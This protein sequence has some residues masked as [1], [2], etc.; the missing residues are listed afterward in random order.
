LFFESAGRPQH[1]T[2]GGFVDYFW[3]E[4]YP[5]PG[6]TNSSANESNY[7]WADDSVYAILG[8]GYLPPSRLCGITN[9]MNCDN[10]QGIYSFHPGGALFLFGDGAANFITE[11][12][13]LD[14]FL[15]QFTKGAGDTAG[16]Y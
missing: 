12:I 8:N 13:E 7:Q 11:S 2:N 9:V 4:G 6:M 16:T 3:D 1:F 15:S 10:F 14:T 5:Q